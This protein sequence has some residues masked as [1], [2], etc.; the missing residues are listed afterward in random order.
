MCLDY[1]LLFRRWRCWYFLGYLA[2]IVLGQIGHIFNL[3]DDTKNNKGH[4]AFHLDSLSRLAAKN[5]FQ[6]KQM[7]TKNFFHNKW[8]ILYID[9]TQYIRPFF[10]YIV[11]NKGKGKV[12]LHC[13]NVNLKLAKYALI[14]IKSILCRYLWTLFAEIFHN[15]KCCFL[16]DLN[17]LMCKIDFQIDIHLSAILFPTPIQDNRR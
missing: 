5:V 14:V 17:F 1:P 12:D 15:L 16:K 11:K 6:S 3:F 2:T 13:A 4:F 10:T 7:K 9:N 8:T